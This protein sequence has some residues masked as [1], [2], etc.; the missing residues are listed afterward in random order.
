MFA[1]SIK[2]VA[3]APTFPLAKDLAFAVDVIPDH[4]A[5]E[6]LTLRDEDS[7]VCFPR[8]VGARI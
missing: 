4:A 6:I 3:Q 7:A 2:S 1:D 5:V 8:P